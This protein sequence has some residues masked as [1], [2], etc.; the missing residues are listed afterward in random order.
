MRIQIAPLSPPP[1]SPASPPRDFPRQALADPHLDTIADSVFVI[2]DKYWFR[3]RRKSKKDL[4]SLEGSP[5]LPDSPS[6]LPGEGLRLLY[7][8]GN[9]RLGS[10]IE[11]S[12]VTSV[13]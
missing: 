7:E 8:G 4:T 6:S 1:S 11:Q 3:F 10:N 13:V 9:P 5:S 12:F 2:T